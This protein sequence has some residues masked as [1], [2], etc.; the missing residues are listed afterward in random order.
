MEIRRE[1]EGRDGAYHQTPLGTSGFHGPRSLRRGEA[2]RNGA[3]VEVRDISPARQRARC[4]GP[5]LPST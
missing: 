5:L 1:R 2:V 3:A 4:G